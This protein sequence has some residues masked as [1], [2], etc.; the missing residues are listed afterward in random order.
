MAKQ[1]SRKA[2]FISTLVFYDE[3]QLILLRQGKMLF[4]AIAVPSKEGMKF[5]ATT[6][7]AGDWERYRADRVDL[8]YLFTFPL[9]R[10]FYYFDLST[11]KD[12]TVKMQRFDGTV[13]DEHFPE[14]GFFASDHTES[15]ADDIPTE[16]FETLYLDGEWELPELGRFQQKLSDIYTF[17]YSIDDWR[18][19]ADR[20]SLHSKRIK[21]SFTKRPFRGGSSYGAYF[22]DLEDR[23]KISERV[24]LKSIEKA[25][26][27]N[28][29]IAGSSEVFD[30]VQQLIEHYLAYRSTV[31]K[32]YKDA[33]KYLQDKKLLSKSV[34][35]FDPN[36][37]EAAE[38]AYHSKLLS[39]NLNLNCFG[40]LKEITEG[41]VLGTLK[42]ILAMCRRV[43]RAAEFFAQGRASFYKPM[44]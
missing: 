34:A 7:N 39:D 1:T 17:V 27:G 33:H 14:T 41:N 5:L 9:K 24:R 19:T 40:E 42:V 35:N 12:K 11:M 13:P 25:S 44:Q 43:E 18:E 4:L 38:L 15:E 31:S 28:M 29:K 23:L 32:A 30:E 21:E 22:S 3:P 16:E 20:N 2:T 26:P 36:A 8:R 10:S 6:V 37:T